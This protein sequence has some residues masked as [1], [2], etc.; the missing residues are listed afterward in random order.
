[1]TFCA[2]PHLHSPL[3]PTTN[4]SIFDVDDEGKIIEVLRD[5][6]HTYGYRL[7]SIEGAICAVAWSDDAISFRELASTIAVC[8]TWSL[9]AAV[10]HHPLGRL[11]VSYTARGFKNRHVHLHILP[12]V[13]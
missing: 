4:D 10:A 7:S 6:C 13:R 1:M 3:T 8:T 5:I 12:G 11:E 9:S 2:N